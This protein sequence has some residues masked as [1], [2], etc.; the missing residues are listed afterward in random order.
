LLKRK[1][2]DH[3]SSAWA[4]NPGYEIDL[5]SVSARLRVELGGKIVAESDNALVMYELGHVPVYYFPR[6]DVRQE[7]L[8]TTDHRTHCPYKGDAGYF[9]VTAGGVTAENAVWYYDHPY[10]EMGHLKGL[11]GFYFDRFDAWYENGRKIDAPPEIE[12]RINE[13][14]NFAVLHPNL[15]ADWHPEKNAGIR[16]YEFSEH[17]DTVVWWK[18]VDNDEWHESIRSRVQRTRR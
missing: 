14:N 5:E 18:N 13:R 16:P 6:A 4:R 3:P 15:A 8:S 1:K 11:L 10:E 7:L 2:K 17:S 12:G 9:S